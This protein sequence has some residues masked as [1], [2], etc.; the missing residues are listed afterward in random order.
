MEALAVAAPIISSVATV[1]SM[2]KPPPAVGGGGASSGVGPYQPPQAFG[3]MG[4]MLNQI[5]QQ[6]S[7]PNQGTSQAA[8]TGPLMFDLRQYLPEWAFRPPT[9][10]GYK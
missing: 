1:A 6:G 7:M 8:A 5:I 9:S 10:G 3:P 2:G 4:A